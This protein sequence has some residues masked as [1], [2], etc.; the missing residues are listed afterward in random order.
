MKRIKLSDRLLPAYSGPEEVFNAVTHIA[1]GALA[2]T[3]LV[4]CLIRS[5]GDPLAVTASA[6]YG[7]SMV[8]LYTMSSLYHALRAGTAKKVLQILDHCTIYLLIAGTYT[9]IVLLKLCPAY[10]AIGWGLLIFQW[11]LTALNVTLNAI[12]LKRYKAFSMTCYICLGWAIL[13]FLAQA[14]QVLTDRGFALLL[15]GGIA[16]TVGAILFAIGAKKPWFHSVFHIFVVLGSLL[17]FLSIYFYV[18]P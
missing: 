5:A 4:L 13:P 14:R 2:I 10:P 17:Q 9:P 12:D 15:S 18:L 3:V 1:G 8:V 16:Y 11:V 7:G 6:I